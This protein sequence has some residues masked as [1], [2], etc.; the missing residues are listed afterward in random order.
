MKTLKLEINET[1]TCVRNA[2][3][4]QFDFLGVSFGLHTTQRH[5]KPCLG[6][7]ALGKSVKRLK[8]KISEAL[9]PRSGSWAEVRDKLNRMLIDS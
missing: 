5:G 7:S 4:E 6:A 9:R 3:R 2:R 1:K 8:A